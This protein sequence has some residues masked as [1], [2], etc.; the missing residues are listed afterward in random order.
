M[1]KTFA[2]YSMSFNMTFHLSVFMFIISI[3]NNKSSLNLNCLISLYYILMSLSLS[4]YLSI[5]PSLP[6][7]YQHWLEI[8]C[9]PWMHLSGLLKRNVSV[10]QWREALGSLF[11]C[12]QSVGGKASYRPNE[13]LPALQR[14]IWQTFYS[15]ISLLICFLLADS[16]SLQK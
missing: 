10:A 13:A 12:N 16:P 2:Q 7:S 4:V 8:K 15:T 1:P 9:L 14:I 6:L 5:H 11:V 3:N